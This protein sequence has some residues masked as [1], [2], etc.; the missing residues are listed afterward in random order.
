MGEVT[1]PRAGDAPA[2]YST[3]EPADPKTDEPD[4]L[5]TVEEAADLLGV[6]TGTI[7]T[8][9]TRGLLESVR[10]PGSRSSRYRMADLTALR[11]GR[12]GRSAPDGEPIDES[13]ITLIAGGRYWY[14]GRDPVE[15][16]DDCSF[17]QV[18][19]LLWTGEL[20][21][22]RTWN[23]DTH[24]SP[25]IERVAGLTDGRALPLWQLRLA[26]AALGGLDSLRFGYGIE[27]VSHTARLTITDLVLSL[28]LIGEPIQGGGLASTLWPR[29]TD[30]DPNPEHLHALNGALV[31]MADH[32]LAPSTVTVRQAASF[33]VDPHG[34]IEVGLAVVAGGWHGGR[35][36]SAE[37]MLADIQATGDAAVVVGNRLRV[38]AVPCLGHP[39]YPAGDPRTPVLL[40]L[41]AKAEPG[42]PVQSAVAALDDI[43]ATRALP[44]PTAEFGL[45]AL[46]QT[47]GFVRGATEAL[48]GIGRAA[49]WV[50][51]ALEIY[52]RPAP[53]PGVAEY[54]GPPPA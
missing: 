29:L 47:F 42:H 17:E 46:S 19:E 31:L 43:I 32:A 38:G 49:G 24:R 21:T 52:G 41:A 51:H 35:A 22:D 9:V 48:F 25:A 1:D 33:R 27:S 39:R 40:A 15:L 45:A 2:S 53:V 10:Q 6:K 11:S 44:R 12:P 18:A 8:Y 34:V 54:T 23:I 13:A 20:P 28:P 5:V 4:Q 3:G 16:V 7:Y 36:L 50:A 37:A 30:R 26:A 14:R